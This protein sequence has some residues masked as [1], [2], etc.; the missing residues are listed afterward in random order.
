MGK[1]KK[2]SRF[3]LNWLRCG[4]CQALEREAIDP[5]NSMSAGIGFLD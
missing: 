5:L 2:I 1:E 4:A 3:L